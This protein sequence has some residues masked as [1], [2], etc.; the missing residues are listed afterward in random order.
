M[1]QESVKIGENSLVFSFECKRTL[2]LR[3]IPP[4]CDKYPSIQSHTQLTRRLQTEP[5]MHFMPQL[6]ALAGL[7]IGEY[8]PHG[9]EILHLSIQAPGAQTGNEFAEPAGLLPCWRLRGL[10]VTGDR[11]VPNGQVSFCVDL[12]SSIDIAEAMQRETRPLVFQSAGGAYRQVFISSAA[13]RVAGW[14]RGKGQINKYPDRWSPE[15]VDCSFMVYHK[16]CNFSGATGVLI[17]DDYHHG[18]EIRSM[19]R[20]NAEISAGFTYTYP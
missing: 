19:K 16:P 1:C 8:G 17:W 9:A 14:Y 2:T 4:L 7:A 13:S 6:S 20:S 5:N 18:S 11:N 10:K 3:P 15:W 12:S